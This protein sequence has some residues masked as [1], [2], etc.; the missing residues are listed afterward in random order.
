ME[1]QTAE[2]QTKQKLNTD[3]AVSR[4]ELL[5]SYIILDI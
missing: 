2:S 5:V 4:P 3:A 1:V